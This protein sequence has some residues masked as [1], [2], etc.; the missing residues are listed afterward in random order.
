VTQDE[1]IQKRIAK[2]PECLKSYIKKLETA[3]QPL[4][5]DAARSLRAALY[6]EA[7]AKKWKQRWE[8]MI[9]LLSF[10][11]KGG[12]PD[13]KEYV[14]YILKEYGSEIGK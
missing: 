9:E 14:A 12:H 13:A 2:L 7:N 10:A 11:E 4:I 5:E 3:R 1:D 6:A 8:A